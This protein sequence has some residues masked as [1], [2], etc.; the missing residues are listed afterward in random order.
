MDD[1]FFDVFGEGVDGAHPRFDFV[2]S[3]RYVG[4]VGQE[5]AEVAQ[6]FERYRVQ[7]PDHLQPL[8]FLLDAGADGELDLFW[9]RPGVRGP[10]GDQ[11]VGQMGDELGAD[12]PQAEQAPEDDQP[13]Q[14]VRGDAIAREPGQNAVHRCPGP[15]SPTLRP[16]GYR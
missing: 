6:V 1:G 5:Y 12:L 16:R 3:P 15:G 11:V 4:A 7:A 14:Q 2:E 13:H 9:G 10:D 8:Q